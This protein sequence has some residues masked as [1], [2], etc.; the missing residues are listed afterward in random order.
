M[1]LLFDSLTHPTLTGTFNGAKS[2]FDLLVKE[3]I[4][5][6]NLLHFFNMEM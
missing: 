3:N 4:G 6:K 1:T 5:Y 2:D